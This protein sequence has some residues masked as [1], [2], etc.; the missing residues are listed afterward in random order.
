M[1][2]FESCPGV[3]TITA[4]QRSILPS[5][6]WRPNEGVGR[7]LAVPGCRPAEAKV[8]GGRRSRRLMCESCTK[9]PKPLTGPSLTAS[10]LILPIGRS[11]SMYVVHAGSEDL[12]MVCPQPAPR[13]WARRRIA[14]AF[15]GTS[16]SV[17]ALAYPIGGCGLS[18][19][20]GSPRKGAAAAL[21]A[22]RSNLEAHKPL[23]PPWFTMKEPT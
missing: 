2:S 23:D 11:L 19:A 8:V 15:W 12:E 21:D 9:A 7:A 13:G 17:A 16:E 1:P 10:I 22:A 20:E 18:A 6:E 14:R 5:P 4:D 3:L